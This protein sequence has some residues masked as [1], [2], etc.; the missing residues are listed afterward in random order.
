MTTSAIGDFLIRRLHEA[1][2]AHLNVLIEPGLG[3]ANLNFGP[4]GSQHRPGIRI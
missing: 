2:I 3:S 4:R 1:G